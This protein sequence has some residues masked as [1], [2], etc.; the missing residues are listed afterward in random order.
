MGYGDRREYWEAESRWRTGNIRVRNI[1]G[2]EMVV[3]GRDIVVVGSDMVVRHWE[4]GEMYIGSSL[5][6][7][8]GENEDR[9]AYMVWRVCDSLNPHVYY[10]VLAV[11]HMVR[12]LTI[13]LQDI[14]STGELKGINMVC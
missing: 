10:R 14:V 7:W 4:D 9:S 11:T 2:K 12:F 6:G 13:L 5:G 3:I 8:D 1:V